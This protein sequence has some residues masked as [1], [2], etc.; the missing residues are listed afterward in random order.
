FVNLRAGARARQ[1]DQHRREGGAS[2]DRIP[3]GGLIGASDVGQ[4]VRGERARERQPT[5][6]A[7]ATT[8]VQRPFLSPTAVCVT[9]WVRTIWFERRYA[10]FFSSQLLSGSNSRPSVVAS[11]SAASSSA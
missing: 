3:H 5:R 7:A 4:D 10:S 11:I 2:D 8:V 6:T 1:H 9:F